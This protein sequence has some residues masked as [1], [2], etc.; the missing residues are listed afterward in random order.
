MVK[1]GERKMMKM[2]NLLLAMLVALLAF[3]F[4]AAC[5]EDVN[6]PFSAYNISLYLGE[7]T[8]TYSSG[9]G[10]MSG[11]KETIDIGEDFFNISDDEKS[12]ADKDYLNFIIPGGIDEWVKVDSPYA[13]Y[14]YAFK[15]TGYIDAQHGYV[16]SNGTAPYLTTTDVTE[17]T[18]CWMYLYFY[19]ALTADEKNIDP[20][21]MKFVRSPFNKANQ[22]GNMGTYTT[23][24]GGGPI[25]TGG[26]IKT[27][28]KEVPNDKTA[29]ALRVY[30][31]V[32]KN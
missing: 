26:E 5:S 20:T 14:P 3:G 4:L 17:Q 22:T 32:A 2:K 6:D 18:E 30:K 25:Y 28:V 7:Y 9:A 12:G 13:D 19:V 24:S 29:T 21:T 10:S 8:F 11:I 31:P 23:A 1:L 27:A 16:N 15:F